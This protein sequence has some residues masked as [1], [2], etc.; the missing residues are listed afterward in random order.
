MINQP[1]RQIATR[2]ELDSLLD[3]E[4]II[5]ADPTE[6]GPEPDQAISEWLQPL[7]DSVK[8]IQREQE[9][10]K[11]SANLPGGLIRENRRRIHSLECQLEETEAKICG[12]LFERLRQ[13]TQ[14]VLTR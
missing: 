1:A 14:E 7:V 9:E 4:G 2:T 13:K 8:A 6:D 10:L 3:Q 11:A 12:G 5:P